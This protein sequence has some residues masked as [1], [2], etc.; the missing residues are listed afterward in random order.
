M[1]IQIRSFNQQ[2][3][4]SLVSSF[5]VETYQP[6]DLLTNWLQPRWEYMYFHPFT[7]ALDLSKIGIAE[8]DGKIVGVVHFEHAEWQVFFQI[9]PGYEYI[10]TILF[11]YAEDNF[12][13][14]T[15]NTERSIR[16]IYIN[17]FDA[18][19]I[20][21]AKAHG[22]QIWPELG[23]SMSRWLLNKPTPE[24][25]LPDGFSLHSLEDSLELQKI[26]QVLWRGF[27]H[28]GAPP[29]EGIDDRRKSML[30]PHFRKDLTIVVVSADGNYVSYCGMWVVLENR[31][32]YVEPV[33]TDPD[34]RRMGLGKAAVMESVRRAAALGAEVAWVGSDLPFYHSI[35]FDK[36]YTT[37]P[38]VKYLD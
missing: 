29:E 14:I 21:I 28:P 27:N 23:E 10:K 16:A 36:A 26:H 11:D 13:G 8:D 3:D 24:L 38:W 32:A 22:Y 9:H 5:L 35:G 37:Y 25:G 34:F 17:D 30:A 4:F 2:E 1:S 31:I 7:E 19:L 6:G 18:D 12:R 20:A 15:E 33:A